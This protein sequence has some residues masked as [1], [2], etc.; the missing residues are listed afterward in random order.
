M[1]VTDKTKIKEQIAVSIKNFSSLAKDDASRHS[2]VVNMPEFVQKKAALISAHFLLPAGARVIDMGCGTGEVTYVVALLNPRADIIGIDNNQDDIEFARKTYKLPNLSFRLSDIAIPDFENESVD[3]IIN[4]NILHGVYSGAGYNLEAV[5]QLLERQ[6]RKLKPGGIMLIRDYIMPPEDEYVLMELPNTPSTGKAPVHLSDADL[7]VLFSQSAR[8]LPNGGCEGFFID[9]Q[10]PR[11]EGTRLFRLPHKWAVEFIHRKNYRAAWEKEIAQ[12]YTFFTWQ[13]YRREFSKMGMRMV[14]TAP[15]WN[16]WV[17]KNYF[18]GRFQLY[19]EDYNS[20][21]T[22]ATNYF[23]VAQKV[24]DRQSLMLEER[25]PSQ[26]PASD[27]KI[28]VVRDKRTGELHELVKR[29]GEY[30][31]VVPYRITYDNRLVVFVKSGFPRPIVN[32]VSR[33]SHNLDDKKWSGH[34]IEPITM[35]TVNMTDNVDSNRQ[36]IFDY[37]RDYASLRPKSDESWHIGATYFPS[38]DRIDEAIEPV[39]VE[40][41]NPHKTTWPL[42]KDKDT[43]FTELGVFTELDA[44]D[45]LLAAQVGL[46]PEPR[47]ELHVMSLMI[48]YNMPFP[49]WVGESFPLIPGHSVRDHDPEELLKEVEKTEFEEEEKEAVHLKPVRAVFVEEGRVGRTTRGMSAQDVEFIVTDD[50]IEN[51]AVVFP[52]TRDWDNNLLVAL[53]PKILPVPN[54]LGGEGATFNAPSF[55]LPKGVRT[56][57]DAKNFIAAIFGVPMDRVSRL[58]ECYFTHIGVTPQRVYPFTVAAPVEGGEGN[59][60]R[61]MMT[62]NLWFLHQKWGMRS[63]GYHFGGQ[64]LKLM[65]WEQMQTNADFGMGAQRDQEHMKHKGFSLSTEKIAVETN[66]AGYS[67]MPSRILGQR[68]AVVST[69]VNASEQR[70]TSGNNVRR[71]SQSYSQAKMQVSPTPDINNVNGNINSVAKPLI[72]G[73]NGK[74]KG[75]GKGGQILKPLEDLFTTKNK[76]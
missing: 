58:G 40:V 2:Y 4:S 7:L 28:I 62:K 39:F 22:P 11:R 30:C 19:S 31:D 42:R 65:A 45:I 15:Y 76:N 52:I 69:T 63:F 54:R 24:A 71:L 6:I 3:G 41:E 17:V 49:R 55:A 44:S 46:L 12:E 47:L 5:D 18:K 50:G 75:E 23:I 64:L 25:R 73:W 1:T 61:F 43:A 8:P 57:D 35:N 37:V 66:D 20:I 14:F 36:M 60:K 10:M 51:L 74:K 32:A 21:G 68:G 56:I 33:G 48:R 9:E 38:P 16:P 70:K 34:L 72:K 67:P 53:D 59:V 26:K 27:L 29:S 13:D